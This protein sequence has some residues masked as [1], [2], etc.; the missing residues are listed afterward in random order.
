M[1]AANDAMPVQ[2]TGA[3]LLLGL[4]LLASAVLLGASGRATAAQDTAQDELKF[5]VQCSR[6]GG[7]AESPVALTCALT[8]SG[9]PDPLDDEVTLPLLSTSAPAEGGAAGSAPSGTLVSDGAPA[10][11]PG[12]PV[13][14]SRRLPLAPPPPAPLVPQVPEQPPRHV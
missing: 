2:R 4:C 3:R 14:V 13:L 6:V 1:S 8:I 9:L 12:A 11:D 5:A 7:S 10:I